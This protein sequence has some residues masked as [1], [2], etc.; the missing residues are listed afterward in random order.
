MDIAR[1]PSGNPQ[2]KATKDSSQYSSATESLSDA[3]S[4]LR[5]A[6]LMTL[7]SKRPKPSPL[8]G[9]LGRA[10]PLEPSPQLD[11]GQEEPPTASSSTTVYNPDT[12]MEIEE[13][14]IREEGEIS[15]TDEPP[16]QAPPP[17]SAKRTFVSMETSKFSDTSQPP[18]SF[19]LADSPHS[20]V[21]DSH[22]A[23]V[24][25]KLDADHVRPGIS[26]SFLLFPI[27]QTS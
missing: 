16:R 19:P 21:F 18:T 25:Y 3:A 17:R 20:M 7:K 14:Q 2:L 13:G 11:Y 15:D 8:P 10:P 5:A 9:L 27:P 12:R 26:C 6:A 22:P 4:S 1:G 24:P 23:S